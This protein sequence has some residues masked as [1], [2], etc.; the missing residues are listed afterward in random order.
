MLTLKQRIEAI[1]AHRTFLSVCLLPI[2]WVFRCVVAIR[3]R[4]YTLLPRK[5]WPVPIVVVG[6]LSVGGNGKTPCV[7]AL[8]KALLSKGLRPG[9]VSRGYGVEPIKTPRLVV[10]HH[11]YQDVGDEPLLIAEHT[12]CPVVVCASR[13]QAVSY[14][15]QREDCDVVISDDGLQHYALKRHIEIV[16]IGSQ[17]ALGNR[18]CLPAGPLRE[19]LSRLKT[20][21][22]ILGDPSL[23][24]VNYPV[25]T[26]YVDLIH[27][28]TGASCDISVFNGEA[29]YAYAAIAHPERFFHLLRSA[30][31][32]VTPCVYPDHH[33][34][35]EDDFSAHKQDKIVMTEKDAIKCRELA[36][37]NMYYLKI[38]S[39][40]DKQ[41]V[42]AFLD[43]LAQQKT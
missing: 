40:L 28:K 12:A 32:K 38:E 18:Y 25:K 8:A 33:A 26:K 10:S 16:M 13:C 31:L 39:E 5:E 23:S 11:R 42:E 36:T 27:L 7:I 24:Y 34:F 20:V 35:T 1:W 2:A 9:I 30:S 41:F 3:R 14:L 6:N 15:L 22:W 19:P 17:A 43:H 29:V 37:E 21:D 4:L